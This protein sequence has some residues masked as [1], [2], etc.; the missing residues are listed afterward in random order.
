MS[1][2]REKLA[3]FVGWEPCSY[4]WKRD[5]G[6]GDDLALDVPEPTIDDYIAACEARGWEVA[7]ISEWLVDGKGNRKRVRS[8]QIGGKYRETLTGDLRA[9]L[10]A[11]ILSALEVSE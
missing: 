3:R 11:A 6:V 1:T 8:A 2:D 4:G 9:A 7:L 10:E 5:N